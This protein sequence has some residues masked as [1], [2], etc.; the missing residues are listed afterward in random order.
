MTSSHQV[1]LGCQAADVRAARTWARDC[2]QSTPGV[3]PDLLDDAQLVVSELVTNAVQAGCGTLTVEVRRESDGVRIAVT[4]DARGAPTMGSSAT[5]V[6]HGRGLLI[7]ATI[8]RSWGVEHR[9][10]GKQ[11]WALLPIAA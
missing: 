10:N 11:V 5:N 8:A 7:V 2:L 1:E 6:P 3:G 9:P 4:D